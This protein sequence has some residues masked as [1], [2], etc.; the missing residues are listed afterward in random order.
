MPPRADGGADPLVRGLRPRRP[1]GTLQ[2]ADPIVPAA[3]RGVPRGPGGPPHQFGGIPA[4]GLIYVALG[5]RARL[6][7]WGMLQ[8]ANARL[9]ARLFG[10]ILQWRRW[11]Y[12]SGGSGSP[13]ISTAPAAPLRMVPIRVSASPSNAAGTRTRAGTVNSNS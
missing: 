7:W 12:P 3:G 11:S 13:S 8:L 5:G 10:R 2:Y 6:Y 4:P 9:R 1:A